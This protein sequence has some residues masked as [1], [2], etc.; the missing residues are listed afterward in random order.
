MSANGLL[1]KWGGVGAGLLAVTA[2][3]AAGASSVSAQS[4]AKFY[5]GKNVRLM[6]GYGPGGSYDSYGRLVARHLGKFIPGKPT[7]VPQNKPGSGSL[8]ASNYLYNVAPRDGSVLAAIGQGV[9]FMQLLERPKIKFDARK[10]TWIGRMTDVTSLVVGW[11]KSKAK[12][13]ADLQ[14]VKVPIAVGGTLSGS[15]LTISFLNALTGTKFKPI[16]GYRAA[17]AM[18]AMER[19]EVDATASVTWLA[20]K[21]KYGRWLKAKKVNVLVQVGLK[22]APGL[23]KVPLLSDLGPTKGDRTMLR[24]LSSTNAI[25]RSLTAP[26]GL[27]IDRVVALRSAFDAMVRSKTFLAEAKRIGH[28]INPMTGAALREVVLQAGDLTP[29]MIKKIQDIVAIKY[30]SIRKK[31]KKKKKKKM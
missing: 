22:R 5:K 14:K 16:K 9:Y 2:V 25:G 23:E 26:P 19:G 20:L 28:P 7:V 13:I 4:P 21:A 30:R 8:V 29:K 18:L 3:L 24:V 11:H 10:F 17:A 12:T 15:T 27:P 1:G 31:K 6:I